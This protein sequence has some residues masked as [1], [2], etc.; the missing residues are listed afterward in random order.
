MEAFNDFLASP[1]GVAAYGALGLAGLR[2]VLG[3]FAAFRDGTFVL[4]SLGAFLRS[5]VLGRVFPVITVLYFAY[6]TGVEALMA[7]ALAA[8]GI[9]TA[10][11]LG[12]V[13]E[14]LSEA[15][16]AKTAQKEVAAES[17]GNPVPQ[18]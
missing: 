13:Q 7:S 5:Q 14:S 1:A 16:A 3:T 17:M 8:A 6:S 18:D 4:S 11:T 2:F 15:A 9:Y 12:A 10:E